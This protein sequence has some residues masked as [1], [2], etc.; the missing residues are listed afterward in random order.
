MKG[1]PENRTSIAA[2]MVDTTDEITSAVSTAI[3]GTII[4]AIFV[5]EFAA[6]HWTT[7]Q[8]AQFDQAATLSVSILTAI[9]VILIAWAFWRTR[10]T[11]TETTQPA[12]QPETLDP[13]SRTNCM[14][15]ESKEAS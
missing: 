10:P 13:E 11:S 1:F 14:T 6:G 15:T 12:A 9:A 2:A 7:T 8:A 3:V 4:A 5:G